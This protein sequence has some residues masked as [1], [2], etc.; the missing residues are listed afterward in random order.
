MNPNQPASL[1]VKQQVI[2]RL[3][4]ATNILVTVSSNPSV[5]Q[6]A[7]CIGAT[8]LFNKL[9]KHATAVFSGTVPST[10]EFLQPEKTIRT[11]PDSLRDFIIALDKSKADKLRYKIE[12]K[13]VKIFITPY[14]TAIS[15]KDLE[16]SE[17]DYNVDVVFALGVHKREELDQAIT[18]HGRIL[19]DATV[20]SVNSRSGSDIGAINLR[21]DK[22]SSLSEIV[23]DIAETMKPGVFDA[24]IATAFLTGIVAETNRFSNAKT[25]A[26][27]MNVSAKL[28]NAGANQ[29]LVATKLEPP[30]PVAPPPPPPTPQPTGPQYKYTKMEK[31]GSELPKPDDGSLQIPHEDEEVNI[32]GLATSEDEKLDQINIDEQG[33]LLKQE[34]VPPSRGQ[35]TQPPAFGGTFTASS[36]SNDLEPSTDPLS[37]P[38][39]SS[40][41]LQKDTLE[42][43]EEAVHSPHL[44][45]KEEQLG[46]TAKNLADDSNKPLQGIGATPVNLDLGHDENGNSDDEERPSGAPANRPSAPPVP[47]PMW[48]APPTD[49]SGS[50][51]IPGVP[52]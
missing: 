27:T 49:P 36:Q 4:Q 38:Q 47:P 20:I 35:I 17:G 52:L 44:G 7:A 13:Y 34:E 51:G 10:L 14:H 5:D 21:D 45:Q 26:T 22:A 19:H 24:Q 9:G 42:D 18:A 15:D 30:K 3:N 8:L 33:T 29:Q 28:M 25:V 40:D 32:E 39:I 11:N 12:D 48:P 50:G 31:A 16:F 2:E 46:Q 23:A 41:E 43:I 6:L 1:P 37:Q